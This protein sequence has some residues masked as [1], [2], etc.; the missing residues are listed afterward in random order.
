[1]ASYFFFFSFLEIFQLPCKRGEEVRSQHGV[2]VD[3]IPDQK[4][5]PFST[6][7]LFGFSRRVCTVVLRPCSPH[8]G[9]FHDSSVW[10]R[11]ISFSPADDIFASA[12]RSPL[13]LALLLRDR[14][15]RT[16]GN[17]LLACFWALTERSVQYYIQAGLFVVVV[18][19]FHFIFI[20]IPF[21]FYDFLSFILFHSRLS[22]RAVIRSGEYSLDP[23][24]YTVDHRSSSLGIPACMMINLPLS[25]L[26]GQDLLIYLEGLTGQRTNTA[27]P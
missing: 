1:M 19:G 26:L 13:L 27:L 7:P 15:L 6:L 25:G 14:C 8:P 22:I 10:G 23:A 3:L 5:R 2:H 18:I 20:L 17:D 12:C 21:F 9:L 16:S 11:A 4:P 24:P